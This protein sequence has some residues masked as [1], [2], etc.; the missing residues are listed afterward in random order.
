L[1]GFCCCCC[2]YCCCCLCFVCFGYPGT[3]SVD[4]AGFKLRGPPASASGVLGL[5]VC[6]TTT[7]TTTA[8]STTTRLQLPFLYSPGHLPRAGPTHTGRGPP[9]LIINRENASK[10]CQQVGLIEAFVM[11]I[12]GCIHFL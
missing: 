12:L 7:T 2:C 3:H 1:L 10:P 11:Y 8:V 4:Q 6:D 9:A 5:K